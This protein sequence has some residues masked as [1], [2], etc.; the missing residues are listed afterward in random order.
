MAISLLVTRKYLRMCG[1]RMKE[2]DKEAFIL[3]ANTSAHKSKVLQAKRIIE[4]AFKALSPSL[5]YV[6]FSG[7][8]DST[9]VLDL[10]R[11]LDSHIVGIWSDDE[12]YLPET[13]NYMYRLKKAGINIRQIQEKAVHTEW[14][15]AH[16]DGEVQ[17]VADEYDGVFLGLRAQ[18]NKYRKLYL[19]KY[20]TLHLT[21]KR[22]WLCNPIAWWKIED[23]W[24]YIFCHALDFNKAYLRLS[25]IG[26]PLERQRIG[27]YATERALGYGQ[28][29]ILKKGWPE[30]YQRFC[31]KF[32]Q[33]S[34]YV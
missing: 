14:F 19:R 2:L 24:A 32:S 22:K 28:L 9:V 33:A 30:E 1:A 10:V 27:P 26:V 6:A 17:I 15:T 20:G 5:W 34:R 29:A 13:I 8:K 7:G 16:V 21:S 23:V 11:H 25:E 18:E 31:A 3:Y 12:F 4:S